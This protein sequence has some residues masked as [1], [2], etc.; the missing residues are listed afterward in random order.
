M[1]WRRCAA[2]ISGPTAFL[3]KGQSMKCKTFQGDH[4]TKVQSFTWFNSYHDKIRVIRCLS[5]ALA[6]T[7]DDMWEDYLKNVNLHHH[8]HVSF[9]EHVERIILYV[10]TR[11]F[12]QEGCNGIVAACDVVLDN[13]DSCDEDEDAYGMEEDEEKEVRQDRQM[14]EAAIEVDREEAGGEARGGGHGGQ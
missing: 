4:L 11:G 2:G 13:E 14:L 3:A 7:D 1:V 10:E 5:I 8:Y 12:C 6:F 9:E